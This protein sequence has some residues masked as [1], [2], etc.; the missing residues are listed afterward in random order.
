[1]SQAQTHVAGLSSGDAE[2]IKT[3]AEL[4]QKAAGKVSVTSLSPPSGVA[5]LPSVIPV[6]VTEGPKASHASLR[7]LFEAWRLKPE[8]RKGT[9]QVTTLASFIDLVELHKGANSALF[10]KTTWPEPALTAVI[11]YHTAK[12]ADNCQHRISYAFPLTDEFK[13]WVDHN[14]EPFNQNDFATFVEDHIADMSAPM[15]GEIEAF[16]KLFRSKFA[17]PTEMIDLSR[18][19]RVNVEERVTNA[20]MMQSGESELQFST[21]H[22][23]AKGKKLVVPGLF[24]LCLPVF[25]DGSVVRIPARLRYRVVPGEGTIL[26]SYNLYRW[27]VLLRERVQSDFAIAVKQT[28]LP[29][30]EGAPE[31]G[32]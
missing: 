30:F 14:G 24:M 20:F 19:L 4:A 7:D 17:L 9:A 12:D 29:A 18:G 13:A 27:E 23:D 16:E 10:A 15:D 32:G 26:W 1:M 8:R 21:E 5:G 28:A 6:E 2:A 22:K 11:D 31:I 25:L 3:F